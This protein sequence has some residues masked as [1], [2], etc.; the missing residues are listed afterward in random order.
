M[1]PKDLSIL[2]FQYPLPTERI[3][4]FPMPERDGSKLL[5]HKAGSGN[6]RSTHYRNI[7][8]EIPQG[9][10]LIFNNTKVVEARLFFRKPSGG[11]IEVFCLEPHEQYPDI[12]SAMLQ[13]GSVLWKCLIGGAKKW[14]DGPLSLVFQHQGKEMELVALKKEQRNDHFVIEFSWPQELA[15]ADVLHAA[16][17][18]PLPPYMERDAAADDHIRYQTIYA[19]HDGSVA[20]PTAGL[21]FTDQLL[22]Q[23]DTAGIERGFV[24]LHVG[25]GTF[26]P[27]KAA[28]ME[29]HDMHAE[30]MEVSIGTIEQLLQFLPNGIIPVG[31]TSLRTIESLYWLGKKVLDNPSL[32]PTELQVAQWDPYETQAGEMPSAMDALQGLMAWMHAQQLERL[33]CKT[34]IIIAPGYTCRIITGLITNFHQPQSTLLL[35]VA[36]LIGDRWKDMYQYALDND[37][38]FL[39]YGDGCLLW[40]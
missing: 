11:L 16:G 6:F 18:L 9:S 14:K 35:L 32:S 27:V 38:R 29:A 2:D 36:A 20:A 17:K 12:T 7:I 1:H 28:T 37:Y 4:R 3:A 10:L 26:K 39:S 34:Q 13:K 30:F 23:M 24:T 15:F 40:L 19:Q 21:H 33:L 25:A 22:K 31:T 8:Q 5:V